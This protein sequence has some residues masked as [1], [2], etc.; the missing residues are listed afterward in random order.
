MGDAVADAVVVPIE[1]KPDGVARFTAAAHCRSLVL[2]LDPF[3]PVVSYEVLQKGAQSL[4]E[5]VLHAAGSADVRVARDPGGEMVAGATVRVTTMDEFLGA[6][7]AV[8]VKEAV[9]DDR[10]WAHF[11]GLPPN[12][13]LRLIAETT[14]GDT[15]DAAVLRLTPRERGVVDPL[16]VPEPAALIIDATI[17]EAFLARFPATR[18]STLLVDPADQRR[19]SERRQENTTEMPMRFGAL[20]PG[21]W[22]VGGVVYVDKTYSFFELEDIELK[23]GETRRIDARITPDVF[24]GMITSE[25]KGVAAR[26]LIDDRGKIL[27]FNADDTGVF[28]VVLQHKG[29]YRVTA[30]RMKAQGNVFP[31][32]NIAFTDPS[33]RIEIAIPAGASV[34]TRVRMGDGPPPRSTVWASQRDD[35]GVI[36]RT[37][38]RGRSTD[39][40]GEAVFEDLAP[41]VWTFSVR[42]SESRS[43]AEKS[44][45]VVAGEDQTIDLDLTDAAAIHGTTR[46]LG[47]SPLPRAR[48]ECLFIGPVGNPDRASAISTSEG[49]FE[50][51]LT[52]PSPP[53]ALC[54]VVGPMGT[55]DAVRLS[56]GPRV[57]LTVPGAT[58]TLTINNWPKAGG[59][60]RLWLVAADGRAIG[61]RSV[62][63]HLGQHGTALTIPALAVGRWKLV[64]LQ[65]MP[66]WLAL[67]KGVG[68]SL[69]SLAEVTL[70]AGTTER[71]ELGAL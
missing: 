11:A 62:A 18:V 46:D 53:S 39:P 47:G 19:R 9:T 43:G 32:G 7:K 30:S 34:K 49:K 60:D 6:S 10:G 15:S 17:E 67:A 71:I 21:T 14:S 41:G 2:E 26:V 65:T 66:Q 48:V 28:R 12:R 64:Q 1:I 33:R 55:V 69:P 70:R 44:I 54:S 22:S 29:V 61:L 25:G 24:E 51:D 37:T 3:E 36:D 5:I 57:N 68:A 59:A 4:G 45:T 50:I 63:M 31:I 40:A 42:E 23:P 20:H 27:Y 35:K 52:A 58:A 16:N 38:A 8:I 13:E 56:P